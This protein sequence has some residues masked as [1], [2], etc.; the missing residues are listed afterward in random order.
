MFSKQHT[1]KDFSDKKR[2]P[3]IR[4]SCLHTLYFVILSKK[5]QIEGGYSYQRPVDRK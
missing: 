2:T 1:K 4:T 3:L 5:L